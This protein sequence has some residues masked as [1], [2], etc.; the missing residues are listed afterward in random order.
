[1]EKVLVLANIEADGSLS[2][3]AF[4]ALTAAKTLGFDLYVGLIGQSVQNAANQIAGC[5]AKAIVAVEGAEFAQSRYG[6]D[7]AAAEAI[8]NDTG[9]TIVIVPASSRFNRIIAG[10]AHRLNGRADTHVTKIANEGGSVHVSRWYYRQRMEADY[11]R[12]HKPWCIALE[13]GC[14]EPWSGSAAEATV[15][16]LNLTPSP[17][18]LKTTVTGFKTPSSDLQTI[19]PEAQVLLVAGAG[20]TKKQSDGQVHADEAGKLIL[21]FLDECQAS[22]GGSKSV[23]DLGGEGQS[24]LPFMTHLN[25]IG[26][27]GST[28]RHQKGLSTCCHGEEP[29]VV[30]WRFINERRAINTDPNC[31]WAQGKCDVLYVADAFKVMTRVNELL[32]AKKLQA[33]T[34]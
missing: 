16:N 10:L 23:V 27:T 13:P 32:K 14:Y 26:Q 25:Q 22:L 20:W 34:R 15:T 1:M 7:I 21:G 8:C 33:S 3:H 19:R 11:S 4:E 29:H 18:A 12:T 5:A 31:S 17:D 28:P 2:K 6:T 30:G 24:V 9:A